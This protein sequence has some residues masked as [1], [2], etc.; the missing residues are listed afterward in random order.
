MT[1]SFNPLQVPDYESQFD[2]IAQQQEEA[3]ASVFGQAEQDDQVSV[4]Y[5]SAETAERERV[6]DSLATFSGTLM[7]SLV[8]Q[9]KKDNEAEM[10]AGIVDAFYSDD[11]D[12][13]IAL[14]TFA[15]QELV[16]STSV[17]NKTADKIEASDGHSIVADQVRRAGSWREYGRYVGQIQNN[18]NMLPTMMSF[19]QKNMSVT[20]QDSDGSTRT[21]TYSDLKE[22]E[23][24]QLWMDKFTKRY[25]SQFPGLNPQVAQK[26]VFPQLRQNLQMSAIDWNTEREKI[27]KQER[28]DDALDRIRAAAGTPFFGEVYVRELESRN[29][30]RKEGETLLDKLTRDEVISTDEENLIRVA[31]IL[32]RSDGQRKPAGKVLARDLDGLSQIREEVAKADYEA[33]EELIQ[34][35]ATA[36]ERQVQELARERAAAG[37]PITQG[38]LN[39]AIAELPT[40]PDDPN[41]IDFDTAQRIVKDIETQEDLDDDNARTYL[42]ALRASRGYITAPDVA[43]F[44]KTIQGEFGP[45]VSADAGIAKVGESYFENG[46]A[47]IQ[48]DLEG[49]YFD[50]FGRIDPN[51]RSIFNERKQRAE[52]ALR[53]KFKENRE[54]GKYANDAE[55]LAAALK[56]VRENIKVGTYTIT[57]TSPQPDPDKANAVR[58][59]RNVLATTPDAYKTSL[60]PNSEPYL[61]ELREFKRTGRGGMPQYYKDLA[62]GSKLSAWDYANAQLKVAGDTEGLIKPAAEE[63]VD[64]LSPDVQKLL[65]EYNTGSRSFRAAANATSQGGDIGWFLDTIAGRESAAHGHYDAYNLGGA[66]NG[67]TPIDSGNSA[68]DGRFGVPISQLSLGT[69]IQLGLDRKIFAAGRYQFV[70]GT[71]RETFNR[72]KVQGVV[73]E[74]TIFDA[75]TQDRF[76]IERAKQ[77]I[78]WP[79]ENS[80]QGLINEWRGLKFEDPV[81]LQRM[82]NIIR[83]EPYLQ[84]N[85]LMPGVTN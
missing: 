36:F 80:V 47:L 64:N 9:K 38:E 27:N 79:G 17:I 30:T 59:A 4:N 18:V 67:Y 68:E 5:A 13:G 72:L 73:D 37:N 19:A 50:A 84:P 39:A 65:R 62:V 70:P 21:L 85:V 58:Q 32:D 53:T 23:D 40:D 28:K 60:L 57:P 8:E 33:R 6:L 26:Y 55:S 11:D 24:F 16:D 46:E 22:P 77:R 54:S 31:P 61:E 83:S 75:Q 35:N 66:D 3:M 51:K 81:K 71:L 29:I 74:T 43:M 52:A 25:L 34:R 56:S 7:D 10:Q 69:L 15:E 20:V 78:S 44:S 14:T 2:N 45:Q 82:L 48:S 49:I 1:A 76:A 12:T 41:F 42:N 63:V